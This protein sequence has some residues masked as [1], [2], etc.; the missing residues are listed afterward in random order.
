MGQGRRSWTLTAALCAGYFLVL[1][2]VTVV[3]VALPQLGAGLHASGPA[4]AWVIDAYT[5][6]LAAL[7]LAAGA[8]GDR[9]GHRRVVLTGFAGFGAASA[10]CALAP[11][12]AVLIGGRALQG[13]GAALVL[14]GTLALLA[15]S[16]ES[17]RARS[18]LVG[19]WAA[20]GGAALPAGPILGGLLVGAAGWR[21][22]FWLS[23]PVTAMAMVPVARLPR[24]AE[25]R[26]PGARVDWTGAALVVIAL[27]CVVTAV[28][29]GRDNPA[30]GVALGL[31]AAAA[32]VTF[33][34]TERRAADP[35][36]RVP[37]G[38]RYPLA[39]ACTVAGL[40]NLCVLGS[41]FLLTQAFQDVHRLSPLTAGLVLLPA[42]LPLPLLGAPAG[43]LAS[44]LGPWPASALG[45]AVAAAGFAGI[46]AGIGGPHYPVLLA[47]LAAWGTGIGILTPA[48]VT[49]ALRTTPKAPGTASGASNTARQAGGALGVAVFGAVAGAPAASSFVTDASWLMRGA[50]VAFAVAAAACLAAR[51]HR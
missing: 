48:I 50:A 43:R 6:P 18:R 42:M 1:L 10:L 40:M 20:V 5:V 38:A 12:A 28:I 24:R 8:A 30:L 19:T 11:S 3:N 47:G 31:A 35:L 2:D 49:A 23:V 41:L 15:G 17:E 33:A 14:P 7:L 44:R 34:V 4:L 37:G 13:A 27:G 9:L 16:A 36:L 25:R 22:I 51:R 29:Q 46:A 21:S 26:E 45:L 32:A 39:A